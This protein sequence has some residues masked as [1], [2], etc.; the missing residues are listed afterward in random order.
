MHYES[1][2]CKLAGR[3]QW[4]VAAAMTGEDPYL[5]RHLVRLMVESGEMER[6]ADAHRLF[7]LPGDPPGGEQA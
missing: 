6:A 5:Q 3:G 2:L 7:Q 4:E 1:S